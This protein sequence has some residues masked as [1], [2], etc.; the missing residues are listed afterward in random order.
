MKTKI[1]FINN[2]TITSVQGFKAGAVN[3]GIKKGPKPV[4]MVYSKSLHGSGVS[5]IWLRRSLAISQNLPA[6]YV[7]IIV[8]NSGYSMPLPESRRY[9]MP[10]K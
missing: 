6:G 5:E 4:G 10:L 8:A 1:D 3:A 9:R 2:G 7:H